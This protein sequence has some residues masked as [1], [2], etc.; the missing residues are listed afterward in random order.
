MDDLPML[1]VGMGATAG[2]VIG[3]IVGGELRATHRVPGEREI[4]PILA[5]ASGFAPA[6]ECGPQ[7][8]WRHACRRGFA[9]EPWPLVLP[10]FYRLLS[11]HSQ[12]PSVKGPVERKITS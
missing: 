9:R 2:G 11:A 12:E 5:F 4:T 8:V 3:R 6:D 10:F 1:R 7:V